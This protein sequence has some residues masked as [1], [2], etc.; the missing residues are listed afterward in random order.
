MICLSWKALH[1]MVHSFNEL[2]KFLCDEKVVIH[3]GESLLGAISIFL[4]F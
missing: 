2:C 1:D 3:E 4:K